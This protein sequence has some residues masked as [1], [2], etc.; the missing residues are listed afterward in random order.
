M[1]V[2]KLDLRIRNDLGEITGVAET[3]ER[4]LD[5]AGADGTVVFKVNLCLDELLTNV[6][7]YGFQDGGEHHIDLRLSVDGGVLKIELEDDARAFNPLDMPP[8]DLESGL[9]AREVG[10]LGIHFVRESMDRVAYR[11]AGDRNLLT[12]QRGIAEAAGDDDGG[13]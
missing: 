11:R 6:I 8:P 5:E 9:E 1:S 7:S 12:M 10:G 2:A 3:I 13:G 4:F